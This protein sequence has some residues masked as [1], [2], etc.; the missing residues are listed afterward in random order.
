VFYRSISCGYAMA[1]K[2]V[3]ILIVG[4]LI[5]TIFPVGRSYIQKMDEKANA[6]LESKFFGIGFIRIDSS[7]YEIKGLVLF[8]L[9]DG[10][11]I[12]SKM[13]DIK[14]DG[15]PILV[16]FLTSFIFSIKYNPTE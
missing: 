14:Y 3:R 8:G 9:N 1:K 16:D 2:V 4:L 11:I 7:N 13:I 12:L 15:T 10:Q 5:A 6:D